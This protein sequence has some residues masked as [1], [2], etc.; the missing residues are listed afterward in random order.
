MEH[1]SRGRKDHWW[2]FKEG[3]YPNMI[4]LFQI[5]VGEEGLWTGFVDY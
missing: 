3:H 5:F 4:Q 2:V 1:N